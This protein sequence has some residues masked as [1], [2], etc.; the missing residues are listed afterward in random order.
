MALK[1][2]LPKETKGLSAE[3]ATCGFI[4]KP[5]RLAH[6]ASR[7]VRLFLLQK[8]LLGIQ[9]LL[10]SSESSLHQLT[11]LLDCRGLHKV[12]GGPGGQAGGRAGAPQQATSSQGEAS[13]GWESDCLTRGTGWKS[14]WLLHSLQ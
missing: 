1:A 13:R 2:S 4:H 7:S 3:A 14:A 9:L 8:D 11:A 6:S 5:S 12:R 10:N